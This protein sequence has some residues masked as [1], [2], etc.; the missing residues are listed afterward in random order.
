MFLMGNVSTNLSQSVY[1]IGQYKE[2]T[3]VKIKL[4]QFLIQGKRNEV[5]WANFPKA[6]EA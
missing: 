6:I 5:W 4:Q 3:Q 2:K 1:F